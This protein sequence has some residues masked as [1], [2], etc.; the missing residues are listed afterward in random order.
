MILPVP[1]KAAQIFASKAATD[2]VF[3]AGDDDAV[4]LAA[5]NLRRP[6]LNFA[7]P[8]AEVTA[9]IFL[10]AAS[11]QLAA[12]TVAACTSK[13][14]PEFMLHLQPCPGDAPFQTVSC[15]DRDRYSRGIRKRRQDADSKLLQD[16]IISSMQVVP[17]AGPVQ[18]NTSHMIAPV[19][20]AIRQGYIAP[21]GT[22][23]P[24][25]QQNM[26]FT[27]VGTAPNVAGK[28]DDDVDS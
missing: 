5:K 26:V 23:P 28:D 13:I 6:H 27:Q 18:G 21:P 22:A 2:A 9:A 10:D 16:A 7:N 15:R 14:S 19:Q 3:M 20:R 4:S 25:P 12:S 17:F 8:T 11:L 24:F 1:S